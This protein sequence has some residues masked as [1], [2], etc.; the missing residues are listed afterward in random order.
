MMFLGK[1]SR[2]MSLKSWQLLI[3]MLKFIA[4]N[5]QRSMKVELFGCTK[6]SITI[7]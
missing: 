7:S 6:S 4:T 3:N 1:S 2:F 5:K